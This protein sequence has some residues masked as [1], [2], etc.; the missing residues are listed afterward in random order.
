MYSNK[1]VKENYLT[2][3]VGLFMDNILYITMLYDFYGELLTEKQRAVIES[4][5]QNDLS[6][7]EI[8]EQY[9]ITRQAVADLVKRTVNIL[10]E[11][12]NKLNLFEKYTRQK[13]ILESA[14]SELD[15]AIEKSKSENEHFENAKKMFL[16]IL[17]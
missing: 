13:K 1:G 7:N 5:Y 6:L 3:L 12:E 17:E 11:Y 15:K 9:G 8:G 16:S 2:D 4:Y 10:K 14:V